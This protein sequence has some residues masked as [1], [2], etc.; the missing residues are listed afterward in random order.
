MYLYFSFDDHN[1]TESYMNN[2]SYRNYLNEWVNFSI[3]L[4]WL[5]KKYKE[6]KIIL[7]E[8]LDRRDNYSIE[9]TIWKRSTHCTYVYKKRLKNKRKKEQLI[10]NN[11]S[12]ILNDKCTS[13]YAHSFKFSF[14]C[15][16]NQ[17]RKNERI[18]LQIQ[19]I[20]SC[21]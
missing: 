21:C 4:I 5:Y 3:D 6:S 17:R 11:F 15:F 1:G 20:W 14:N 16:E 2:F 8:L 10:K 13:T 19:V 7:N 12:P 9:L 18:Y